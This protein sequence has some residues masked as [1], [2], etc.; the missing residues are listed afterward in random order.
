MDVLTSRSRRL[1]VAS[2]L[3]KRFSQAARGTM[4]RRGSGKSGLIVIATP[5][6]E[7]LA[8]S[9]VIVGGDG[10]V[11]ARFRIGLPAHGRRAGGREAIE[12]LTADVP[13]VV[14]RSLACR[15]GRTSGDPGARAHERGC[16]R[17]AGGVAH[18]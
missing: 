6:Q 1:G 12:L 13:A 5:G 14:N 18:P 10:T 17:F 11:E 16:R 2:L 8:Q 7:V 4:V 9:A 3:A 15:I